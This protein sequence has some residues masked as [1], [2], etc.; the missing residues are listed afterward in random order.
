[1]KRTVVVLTA[2]GLVLGLSA[3]ATQSAS[4]RAKYTITERQETLNKKISFGQRSGELTLKE[5]DSLRDRSSN[6]DQRIAKMKEKNGG[7]LSYRDQNIIEKDLN[8]LSLS[9]SKKELS[10][11]AAKPNE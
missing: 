6:I 1:M 9:I 4:A 2:L 8:K 5:A 7:K 11:R 3:V 10:K